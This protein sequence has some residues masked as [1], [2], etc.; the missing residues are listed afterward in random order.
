MKCVVCHWPHP[1]GDHVCLVG[2]ISVDMENPSFPEEE[3]PPPFSFSHP[4]VKTVVI[5][6]LICYVT[7]SHI[8]IVVVIDVQT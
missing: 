7:T 2:D 5:S 6:Q 4:M 1:L 8:M 3:Q